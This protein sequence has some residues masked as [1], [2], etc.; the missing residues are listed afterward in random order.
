MTD[1]AGF[2]VKEIVV[3]IRNDVKDLAAKIDRI[4]REGSIGTRQDLADHENRLRD[5]EAGGFRLQGVWTTLGVIAGA[6]AGGAGL[7][8]G[9]LSYTA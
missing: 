5:L 7:V 1:A 4:D 6:L 2:S 3:E 8:L 9:L